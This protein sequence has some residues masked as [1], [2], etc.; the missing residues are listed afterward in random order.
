M[1][2]YCFQ[3]LN[4]EGSLPTHPKIGQIVEAKDVE[5]FLSFYPYRTFRVTTLMD[6]TTHRS[7]IIDKL[8]QEEF[9][10][11]LVESGDPI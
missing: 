1:I 10:R 6:E 2:L 3:P 9:Q 7:K 11:H 5:R 4:E 8:I